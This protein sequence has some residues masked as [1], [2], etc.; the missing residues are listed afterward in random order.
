MDLNKL[1]SAIYNDVEAG[2]SNMNANPNI[3][4]EQLEDEVIEYREAIIKEFYRKGLLKPH[5][6]MLSIN[7]IDVD[8]ADP[9]KCCDISSGKSNVHFEIPILMNDLGADAID[10]IGAVDKTERYDVVLTPDAIKYR[11]YRKRNANKPYVYIDRTPNKNGLYDG[12]IFNAPFV[13]KISITAIF[14]DPR[15]I[16]QFNCCNKADFLDM[17]S[18]TNEIKKRLVEQKLRWYRQYATATPNNQ[19]PK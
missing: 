4:M 5:D 10:W 1:T 6:L 16:E 3:S 7:C 15:Q 9:A 2:L 11:K 8:C 12:W 14:K 13:K 18:I 17:G 19:T